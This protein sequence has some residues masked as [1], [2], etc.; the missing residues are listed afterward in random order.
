[1]MLASKKIARATALALGL[2]VLS[3]TGCSGPDSPI[4]MSQVSGT[5]TYRGAPLTKGT[6]SFMPVTGTNTSTGEIANGKYSL[7]T[8][9]KGD[10]VPPGE[11]KVAITAW[12]KE[13]GM[14][15]TGVSLLPAKY[16]DANSSGLTANVK[17]EGSQTIDFELKD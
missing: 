5:V 8:F 9:T 16:L 15:E 4:P 14:G 3:A 6:I 17:P 10:G 12:E 1:M 7:S 11:Y 13:P 2:L